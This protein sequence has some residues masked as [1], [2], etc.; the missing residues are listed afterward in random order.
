MR[1][2]R[3]KKK[4]TKRLKRWRHFVKSKK[5]RDVKE[6]PKTKRL[7]KLNKPKSK[8]RWIWTLQLSTSRENGTGSKPRVS[9]LQRKEREERRVKRRRSDEITN[10]VQVLIKS[11]I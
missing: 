6:K 3:K 4:L 2:S 11:F 5:M 7:L 9:S 1:F 10:L 8:K